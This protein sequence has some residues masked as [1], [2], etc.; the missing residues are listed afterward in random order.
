MRLIA[1]TLVF[2]FLIVN[3]FVITVV[4][5]ET[6]NCGKIILREIYQIKEN[7][8]ASQI[9]FDILS[10]LAV[11]SFTLFSVT[12]VFLSLFAI[13][14]F[15][16]IKPIFV[17]PYLYGCSLSLLILV[18]GIIQ[19]LVMCWKLTHSEY[20]DNETVEASTKYLNYVYTGAGILLM[21]FI[22]V[23][24]IIAAYYDVKRLHIN[25]LEWIYKERSTAFN[26]TDLIFLENKGR[27]LNSIDM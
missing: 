27:I 2:A 1:T 9:Y 21:Y 26:P 4:I 7:D 24:I 11:T 10:C 6:E 23:S 3:P 8:K 5:R 18:F 17:K 13:Y 14:G 15:F 25:L 16:S 20:M 19:S 12:H 22:W